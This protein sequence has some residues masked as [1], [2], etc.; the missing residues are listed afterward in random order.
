MKKVVVL[1]GTGMLGRMVALVLAEDP[2]IDVTVT[3]RNNK[4]GL[5]GIADKV[6]NI[7]SDHEDAIDHLTEEADYIVNC[8][9]IT[10]PYLMQENTAEI[11][12]AV[13]CNVLFP[14]F[15]AEKASNNNAQVIQIATDCVYS[16]EVGGYDEGAS[17]DATDAYGK[18]KSL[19]EVIADNFCNIRASIIGPEPE[20]SSFLMSWI[21]GQENGSEVNGFTN[22]QWNGVTTHTFAKVCRGIILKDLSLPGK[23]HLVPSGSVSKYQLLKNLLDAYGCSDVTVNAV[24]A[25]T[26]CDRTLFTRDTHLNYDIWKAA[27]Y[28][29][30]PTVGEMIVEMAKWQETNWK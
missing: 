28:S 14:H 5:T 19:G 12:N 27:G 26:L 17:H 23:V 6:L 9:G 18:T 8:I 24:K 10:K 16:G 7:G 30:P 2:D 15:L 29:E 1:G 4:V 13:A 11:R 21:L 25:G 20:R 22:H 3:T